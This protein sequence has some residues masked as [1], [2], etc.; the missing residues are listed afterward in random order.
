MS[1]QT[2][3]EYITGWLSARRMRGYIRR[4]KDW[5]TVVR[6][7]D[8]SFFAGP[9][10]KI[11][12]ALL[13]GRNYYDRNNFTAISHFVKPG[14]VCFDV[15]ANIGV[16]SVILANVSGDPRNVHAFEPVDHV[17][18]KLTNNAKLNGLKGLNVNDFALGSAPGTLAMHQIK[19]GHFRGGT[20][21][22]TLNKNV[23]KI[24]EGQFDVR[25]VEIRTLDQY[26]SEHVLDRVD[27]V[28]I[29]VEGFEIEVL[30]GAAETI[31]RFKPTIILEYEESR[32][33]EHADTLRKIL[34]G[35]G[36]EVS[37]YISFKDTLV[38]SPFEFDHQPLHRNL[39][40]WSPGPGS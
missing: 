18:K 12:A 30:K 25:Q 8:C 19:E 5:Q 1:E 20:S 3:F 7:R 2:L 15:G 40:C 38:L 22:F 32:H 13:R 35:S 21:T 17:R 6:F 31:N 27:F 28:K 29:D 9:D 37:E 24:G 33:A 14:Y 11:E 4:Q 23:A 39:L 26:V 34:F 16:Y 10:N 36:Y